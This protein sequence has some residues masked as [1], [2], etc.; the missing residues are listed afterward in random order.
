MRSGSPPPSLKWNPP[1]SCRKSSLRGWTKSQA[2]NWRSPARGLKTRY[3][4]QN[5]L[6]IGSRRPMTD[7]HP[8]NLCVLEGYVSWLPNQPLPVLGP[9]DAYNE[10]FALEHPERYFTFE[11]L[12]CS[13]SPTT[14]SRKENERLTVRGPT[15]NSK[16]R[17]RP[18]NVPVGTGRSKPQVITLS[19]G[20]T[21][22]S[23]T[24][25]ATPLGFVMP[26]TQ[27]F[28]PSEKDDSTRNT[29]YDQ[30][31]KCGVYCVHRSGLCQS[32]R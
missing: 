30:C 28:T 15:A 22:L 10:E 29:N 31:Y 1:S 27:S 11:E 18:M 26:T 14:P 5:P 25:E 16:S 24:T 19:D 32:C 2:E 6:L 20:V 3:T 21:K 13:P 8:L 4:T 9:I 7:F 17:G 23:V 12:C